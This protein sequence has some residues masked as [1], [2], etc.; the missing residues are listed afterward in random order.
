[1]HISDILHISA[2]KTKH[3]ILFRNLSTQS[4]SVAAS[5]QVATSLQ[6]AASSEVDVSVQIDISF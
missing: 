3:K 2:P 6:F 5:V 1:M 4:V